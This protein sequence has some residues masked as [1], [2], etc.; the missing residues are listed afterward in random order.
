MRV[1][2][3]DLGTSTGFAVSVNGVLGQCGTWVLSKPKEI[4]YN[5]KLR[6]HRRLD[7]RIPALWGK[8]AQLNQENP[9][10]Y[11]IWEDVEFCS[12]SYQC[13]LW[14]SFRTVAWIFAFQN[15]IQPDCVPVGTLKKFATG[16]GSGDKAAMA[17]ALSKSDSRFKLV[18]G[19][20]QDSLTLD[21]L[22]DDAVDAIWLAKWAREKIQN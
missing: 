4:A 10:D 22:T 17:V 2:G 19:V 12:T 11:I 1:L 16:S 7:P 20:I 8:I 5:R 15:G 18:G 6:M 9:L 13:Q 14:A 3:I 21:F